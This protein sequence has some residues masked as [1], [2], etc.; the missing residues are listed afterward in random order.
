MR[1]P[2]FTLLAAITAM[3]VLLGVNYPVQNAIQRDIA[4][5]RA[6]GAQIFEKHTPCFGALAWTATA[7]ECSS[8]GLAKDFVT[9]KPANVRS[10]LPLRYIE[11]QAPVYSKDAR[12]CVLGEKGG[13]R[14]AMVGDSHTYVWV[15]ALNE[16]AK[17]QHWELHTYVRASCPFAHVKW[18]RKYAAE[19]A[20]CEIW[21]N[22]V[23]AALAKDKPYTYLFT[24][25]RADVNQPL[26]ANPSAA[27]LA[28]IEKSWQ[29]VID[30][31][32]KIVVIRDIPPTGGDQVSC[33]LKHPQSPSVCQTLESSSP[34]KKDWLFA[35][36]PKIKGTYRIDMTKYF[37]RDQKCPAIIGHVFAYRDKNHMTATYS[38]TLAPFL[39]QRLG[40]VVSQNK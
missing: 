21:N 16:I 13:T 6:I 17:K 39:W 15:D 30:R 18:P 34:A 38:R 27:A 1:Q 36:V 5:E 7:R 24:S 4:N 2:R 8:N 3:A 23:D 29:P 31:G 11:C 40:K 33:V 12:T 25:L 28:G 9:P 32:T 22:S 14:V 35:T 20:A 37:C 26:S 19:S 10:D